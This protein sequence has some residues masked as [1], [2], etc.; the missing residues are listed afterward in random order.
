MAE[1]RPSSAIP[2][3][4]LLQ[5]LQSKL[6]SNF[7]SETFLLS[8]F[9]NLQSSTWETKFKNREISLTFYLVWL[10][11]RFHVCRYQLKSSY[12]NRLHTQVLGKNNYR[13]NSIHNNGPKETVEKTIKNI[14]SE[15]SF[16]FIN[17]NWFRLS[18]VNGLSKLILI[19]TVNIFS[20]YLFLMGINW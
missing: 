17:N 13:H 14:F 8:I 3:R 11:N 20:N 1:Y 12:I 10:N 19:L 6:K 18:S 2:S 4:L 5:F 9:K 7:T 16:S 15:T